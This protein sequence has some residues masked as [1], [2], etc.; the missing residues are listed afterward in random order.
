MHSSA[1]RIKWPKARVV[2]AEDSRQAERH[3]DEM[4]SIDLTPRLTA[5]HNLLH[6]Y[7]TFQKPLY[8]PNSLCQMLHQIPDMSGMSS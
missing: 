2:S 8:S 3:G 6:S 5:C 4:I 7:H 1:A